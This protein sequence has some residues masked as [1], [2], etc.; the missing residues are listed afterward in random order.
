MTLKK[1]SQAVTQQINK[2]ISLNTQTLDENL[3]WLVEQMHPLFFTLNQAEVEALSML[4]NSLKHMD[5]H[6]RLLLVDTSHLLMLAQIDSPGSLFATLQQL[7]ERDISYSELTTSE[8][9]LP[10]AKNRLEVLRF[11]YVKKL[12]SEV[13]EQ[14]KITRVP[15]SVMFSV[16]NALSIRFPHFEQD[17]IKDLLTLLLINNSEYIRVS[18]AERIARLLYLFAQTK[19]NDGIHFDLQKI[20]EHGACEEY[21]VL[22]GMANPPVKGFLLQLLAVFNRLNISVHRSYSLTLSDGIHPY[23]LSTFYIR[24]REDDLSKDSELYLNL[25]REIYNTQILFAYSKSYLKLVK[26]G[27]ITGVDASLVDALIGFCHTNLA[28]S[29]PNRYSLEDIRHA[30]HNHPDITTDIIQLFHLRFHP[31]QSKTGYKIALHHISTRIENFNSG[32]KILDRFR[33]TVFSCALSFI[34]HCL[35]TNFYVTKKHALA[36]RLDPTYLDDLGE[37]FTQ[38]LPT[39]QPFRITYFYGRN[40]VAYHIGFSDIARGGWRTIITQGRDNYI[41]SANTLFKENYVLA[42]TQHLKNKDIYEGG[43]KMVAVLRADTQGNDESIRQQLYKLQL[44]FISAFFDIFVTKNGHAKDPRVVDYYGEDEPI[45]LGPDENMHDLMIEMIAKKAVKRGY[46]LKSGVMSSKEIGINHKEYGVTSIG[47]IRFAE[48]TMKTLGIDMHQ[49]SFSVKMTGGP[50]GDVAGNGMKLLLARCPNVKIKLIIDGSGVLYDP[51]GLN[52]QALAAIILRS[53][54]DAYDTS[55]LHQ[56]GFLLYRNQTQKKGIRVLYKKTVMNSN[57]LEDQWISSDRL[58]KLYNNQLFSVKTDLFIPAGGRP[59]TIDI[60]NVSKFFDKEGN[61]S[62][63]VIIEG[64]NSF[65]T[66]EA[67]LELQRHQ[68]VI[69]RDASANKCGVIS[70]SYEIIANL[71]LTDKEFLA[72]KTTYVSDVITILNTMAEREAT[73]ILKRFADNSDALPYTDISTHISRE[74]NQHYAHI[75]EYFQ[76]NPELC[77]QPNYLNAILSHMPQLIRRHKQ[78]SDRVK[79]LPDKLKFAILASKL[80]ST[81]VYEAD[82]NSIYAGMIETQV[83]KIPTFS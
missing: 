32:R 43:S 39:D 44:S 37:E 57:G 3:T 30:F 81:L 69:M 11:D 35:K 50:N 63:N 31:E 72:N 25:Q 41:N 64:A 21:R 6:K 23:F 33:R 58:N 70:S 20:E 82:N 36:F 15:D 48:V 10:N 53:D 65:I 28:H 61:P 45:E 73:L 55:A 42:H 67:R 8:S 52:H 56:D 19:Q 12:E 60:D 54:L 74:I 13:L 66:P 9:S 18:S 71:I 46:L 62:S 59:E 29:H 38:D 51:E 78:F 83:A 80:A 75:F 40:G 79:D 17:K 4:T 1:N 68:V 77:D 27:I 34:K 16:S 26:T 24:S 7:P 14:L 76:A 49:D 5:Y 22:L 2:M 47:V